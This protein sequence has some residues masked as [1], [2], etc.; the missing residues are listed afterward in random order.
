MNRFWI[1]SLYSP[2]ASLHHLNFEKIFAL[3][4]MMV[5]ALT[6]SGSPALSYISC[7]SSQ[8]STSGTDACLIHL[9]SSTSRKISVSLKS[10]NPAVTVP[11]SVTVKQGASTAAFSAT[12]STVTAPQ[13]ATITA[14]SGGIASQYS[15][16]LSPAGQ[17]QTGVTLRSLSCADNVFTG[18]QAGTNPCT[19]VLSSAPSTPLTIALSSSTSQIT[20]PSTIT[21]AAG[22]TTAS[23]TALMNPIT[24][25]QVATLRATANGAS[26]SFNVQL[27]VGPG[28]LSVGP[29]SISFGNVAVGTAVTNSVTLTAVG[30]TAITIS[31]ASISGAGFSILG[32]SLP[33]TLNPGQSVIGTI[34]FSPSSAG[35]VTG[36]LTISSNAPTVTVALSGAGTTLPPTISAVS[37]ASTSITG[38]LADA[39]N[40]T[41]S[42]SAP[43]GGLIVSLA[44]S[45]S[46]VS[47][48]SSITV[49][50]TA[51]TARFTANAA[52]VNNAQSV[53]L[54]ANTQNSSRTTSLQLNAAT[55]ALNINA[56]SL[57]FGSV[58]LN[59]PVVQS[60]TLNSTGTAPLTVASVTVSGPG[61]S[62]SGINLPAILNPGQSLSLD[63]QFDP[64]TPGSFTGQMAIVTNATSPTVALSG[65]GESHQV[66]IVWS[67]PPASSDPV[68]GYHIYRA[69][70]GTTSFQLLNATA[71]TPTSFLDS[72]VASGAAYD[73][74]VK[75]LDAQGVESVPSNMVTVTIP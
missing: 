5:S 46:A 70:T 42:G 62:T 65:V 36:Q 74:V 1:R 55:A 50:A 7:S 20:V 72:T 43:T 33:Y 19:I 29:G 31:S 52:L 66:E 11:G 60:I 63:V 13:T 3:L 69:A 17:S 27:Q 59:T 68:T 48:P 53:T 28:T 39:C 41:L 18:P 16:S 51:A 2:N 73:Y 37:C 47:V 12:V 44:S 35:A 40:V 71:Q 9:T 64:A 57:G 54:T 6:A 45:S 21:V 56:T 75:S 25:A 8:L 26:V 15:I 67:S 24:T 58:T 4:I 32:A 49:P 30:T 61:F 34:Q 10:N 14:Q 23:F 38:S 22:A